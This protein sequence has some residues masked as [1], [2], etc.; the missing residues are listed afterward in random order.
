VTGA[1]DDDE[2]Q[3]Y[4]EKWLE[5]FTGYM[6]ADILPT[7]YI[8]VVNDVVD[9]LRGYSSSVELYEPLE[10]LFTKAGDAIENI[11]DYG[12]S[13]VFSEEAMDFLLALPAVVGVP[14]DNVKRD[15]VA[16]INVFAKSA[17]LDETTREGLVRA[18]KEGLGKEQ[19]LK[20]TLRDGWKHRNN[21]RQRKK[22][23][24]E[25]NDLY[26]EKVR[27]KTAQGMKLDEARKKAASEVK[28]A[29]TNYLKPIYQ[30]K[31][32]VAKNEVKQFALRIG[33]GGKQLYAGYDFS[34]WDE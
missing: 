20:E 4:I 15:V 3:S 16:L 21:E 19:S 29:C 12:A 7:S 18:A 6:I 23:L 31:T 27:K 28:T 17:R 25:I 26:N 1:R 11:Q 14:L 34:S 9:L 10:D 24:E 5:K 32:G 22:A 2:D 30:S 8:P 33:V 13:E